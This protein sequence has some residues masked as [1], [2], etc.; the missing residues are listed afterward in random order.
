MRTLALLTSLVVMLVAI[1]TSAKSNTNVTTIDPASYST[2]KKGNLEV[3]L[4]F[5]EIAFYSD[6]DPRLSCTLP[7][8]LKKVFTQ[9]LTNVS[10]CNQLKTGNSALHCLASAKPDIELIDKDDSSHWL[11]QVSCKTGRSLC[12]D[13]DQR[14]RNAINQIYSGQGN[15]DCQ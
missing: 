7:E 9:L 14:F 1:Q 3:N 8:N 13:R 6:A 11:Q 5:D 15:L 4:E 12:G 10:L 2:F